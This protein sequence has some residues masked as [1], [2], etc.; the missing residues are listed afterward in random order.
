LF[1]GPD[2]ISPTPTVLKPIEESLLGKT[3]HEEVFW[4]G[5]GAT[6]LFVAMKAAAAVRGISSGEVILPAISCTSPANAALLAG[7]RPRFADV[8]P[9][10][11]LATL[12]TIRRRYTEKTCAVVFINLYGQTAELKELAGWCAEKGITLIEDNAQSLGAKCPGGEPA[13]SKGA[14]AIYSFN[15]RKILECGGGAMTCRDEHLWEAINNGAARWLPKC[16][17]EAETFDERAEAYRN[18]YQCM[19][20]LF[21]LG[22]PHST[23]GFYKRLVM[24]MLPIL[25]EPMRAPKA[26]ASAWASLEQT[27]TDRFSKAGLYDEVLADAP[28]QIAGGWRTSGVCWR[29]SL[30][31][32]EGKSL[33]AMTQRI[34]K[35]GFLV[36]NLYMPVNRLL[37]EKDDCPVAESLGRRV[38]NLCVDHTVTSER[39]KECGEFVRG[40]LAASCAS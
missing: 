9:T 36:S 33:S 14:V 32:P 13:G 2:G 28:C 16:K 29:Y 31:A 37:N 4:C 7:L 1:F 15:H 22:S 6:A 11:G 20:G 21:R 39:V 8:E 34:R 35:R 27:L 19:A 24:E 38:L 3:G 40:L 17:T 26:L 25:I 5:R 12:A 10:T 30:F 18:S 23:F